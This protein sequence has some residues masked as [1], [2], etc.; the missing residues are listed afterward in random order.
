MFRAGAAAL[1]PEVGDVGPFGVRGLYGNARELVVRLGTA[2]A[3]VTF[4]SKGAGA[5]D[6][7]SE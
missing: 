1:C 6:P 5:G 3:N 4:L 7:P 2:D